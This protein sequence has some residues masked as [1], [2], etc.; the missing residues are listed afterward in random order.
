MIRTLVIDYQHI[1][2]GIG[3]FGNSLFVIGSVLF[4]DQFKSLHTLAVW[5]FVLGSA[6]MLLGG[7]GKAAKDLYEAEK[8]EI[9][10]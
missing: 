9:A 3:I 4:F 8:D 7:L 5:L 1:H 2:L 6:G 10:S